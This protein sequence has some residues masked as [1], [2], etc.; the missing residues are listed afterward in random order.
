M[1]AGAGNAMQAVENA[2]GDAIGGVLGAFTGQAPEGRKD[3]MIQLPDGRGGRISVPDG[4][5]TTD[6]FREFAQAVSQGFHAVR[7][8]FSRLKS[9]TASV[10]EH[11]GFYDSPLDDEEEDGGSIDPL[12]LVLLLK[13]NGNNSNT[14]G[15]G[16]DTTTLLLLLMHEGGFGGRRRGGGGGGGMDMMTM[17]LLLG[18]L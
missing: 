14:S 3:L 5:V 12:M 13:D 1:V 15:G 2:V 16:I 8:D 6:Q 4:V 9:V 7:Q 10:A 18:K 11:G 17:L